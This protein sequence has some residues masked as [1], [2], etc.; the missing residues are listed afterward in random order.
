MPR[1]AAICL[2]CLVWLV[3]V[4][5]GASVAARDRVP[6]SIVAVGERIESGPHGTFS[7][8]FPSSWTAV[9]STHGDYDQLGLYADEPLEISIVV[10]SRPLDEVERSLDRRQLLD[11]MIELTMINT[12]EL[13]NQIVQ[14]GRVEPLAGDWPAFAAVATNRDQ[15]KIMTTLRSFVAGRA[16]VVTTMTDNRQASPELGALVTRVVTSLKVH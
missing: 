6:N 10:G 14:V 1:I 13:G 5:V 4:G 9:S 8:R 12:V 16:Y 2:A 11:R 15:T 7:I 3:V